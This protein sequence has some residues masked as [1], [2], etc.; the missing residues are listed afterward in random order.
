M[1]VENVHGNIFVPFF[2]CAMGIAL[3]SAAKP[4]PHE[5]CGNSIAQHVSLQ[6]RFAFQATT[7]HK[8][9]NVPSFIRFLCERFGPALTSPKPRAADHEFLELAIA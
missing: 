1:N 6:R 4:A 9:R 8:I 5:Q 2:G 3:D 7:K